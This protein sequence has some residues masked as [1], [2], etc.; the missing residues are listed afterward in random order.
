M[1]EIN[2]RLEESLLQQLPQIVKKYQL[3]D[4]R[5]A[6]WQLVNTLLPFL[7]LWV[8][9]FFLIDYSFWLALPLFLLNGFFLGRLFILQHDCGHQSFTRSRRANNIIGNIL[10]LLTCLPYKY[11]ATSHNFHH[12]HNGLLW[13]HRDIGDIPL[14]TVREFGASSRWQRIRYRVLRNGFV[15][16]ILLPIFY[17]FINNRLPLIRLPNFAFARRALLRSTLL[18]ITF[19][20]AFTWL[21]GI[22]GL[23]LHVAQVWLFG[24]YAL[25]FFYVQHQHETTFKAWKDRWDYLRAAVQGSTF[26][27]LPR[28]LNWLTANIAYHHIHHLNPLVPNYQLK[29]CHNENPVFE[30]LANK[31]TL[32]QSFRCLFNNLWDEERQRMISFREYYRYY[33]GVNAAM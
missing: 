16:F 6:F 5:A 12:G 4:N 30:R 33:R 9:I 32:R 25:W 29:R 21:V 22:E 19:Y 28:A 27:Q 13:E 26:Y 20:A 3:P 18:L 2:T 15:L 31:L 7:G 17:V 11:W 14:L 23:L 24:C 10:A 1:S 8:A